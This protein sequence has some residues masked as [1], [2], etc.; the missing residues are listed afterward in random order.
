MNLIN[1]FL[2]FILHIDKHIDFIIRTYGVWSYFILFLMIFCETGLVVIPFLPGDSLIFAA[3]AFAAKKSFNIIILYIM[4]CFAAV[5]GDTVNYEIGRFLGK[6]I[7]EKE[8]IRF[9]KKENLIKTKDFYER[10]GGFTIIIARFMPIIRTFAPFVAG[11]GK[12]KYLRFISYNAVG[13]IA[14]VTLFTFAGYLFGNI[15]FVKKNF[16]IVIYA[17]V[18]ISLI[19]A[20]V[21]YLKSKLENK[22]MPH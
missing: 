10:H 21:T 19:P 17:I 2:N 12:M 13:G 3:G 20:L 5:L 4:L 18:L 7:F 11:I 6:E 15:D 22:K 16:S 9:I 14:W 1:G 8:K